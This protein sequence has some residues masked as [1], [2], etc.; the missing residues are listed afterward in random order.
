MSSGSGYGDGIRALADGRGI[1]GTYGD[2]GYAD[3]DVD[4]TI[5]VVKEEGAGSAVKKDIIARGGDGRTTQTARGGGPVE[6]AAPVAR[7]EAD[8]IAV[9]RVKALRAEKK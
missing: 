9:G 5:A 2:G 6:G 4:G 7:K 3:G 1:A 8:P